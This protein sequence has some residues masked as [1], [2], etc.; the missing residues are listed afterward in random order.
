MGTKIEGNSSTGNAGIIKNNK[1]NE[2]QYDEIKGLFK[3]GTYGFTRE[4]KTLFERFVTGLAKGDQ[5][6][7]DI[8]YSVERDPIKNEHGSVQTAFEMLFFNYQ[9]KPALMSKLFTTL[10]K[11]VGYEA[12]EAYERAIEVY[13]VDRSY[14]LDDKKCS[15]A[16]I[17]ALNECLRV[18]PKMEQNDVRAEVLERLSFRDNDG[19]FVFTNENIPRNPGRSEEKSYGMSEQKYVADASGAMQDEETEDDGKDFIWTDE[20]VEFA[21]PDESTSAYKVVYR[22]GIPYYE[23]PDGDVYDYPPMFKECEPLPDEGTS[24]VYLQDCSEEGN[25]GAS[26]E[27]SDTHINDGSKNDTKSIS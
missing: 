5:L 10:S 7:S 21:D 8:L 9:D 15:L 13:C 1:K 4:E 11:D 27:E 23:T 6:C 22:D 25:S 19:T 2:I 16:R 3:K 26:E 12:K 14:G 18:F 17:K 24:E 20:T